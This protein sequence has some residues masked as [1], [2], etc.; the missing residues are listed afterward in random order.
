MYTNFVSFLNKIVVFV[1]VNFC[2][3]VKNSCKDKRISTSLIS[4]SALTSPCILVK[5][6][7]RCPSFTA[8]RYLDVPW[9]VTNSILTTNNRYVRG[10][11]HTTTHIC[12][13]YIRIPFRNSTSEHAEARNVNGST[14]YIYRPQL[15]RD[16]PYLSKETG[17]LLW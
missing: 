12:P 1:P 7:N 9:W 10:S 15:L 6:S 17:S 2:L 8:T 16:T 3:V 13:L 5:D 11:V 4:I 14:K